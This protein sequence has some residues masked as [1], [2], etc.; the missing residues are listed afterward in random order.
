[1]T[2]RS[3]KFRRRPRLLTRCQ[4]SRHFT[5]LL[6]PPLGGRDAF[7][8][9]A[10][11]VLI[12]S[13]ILRVHGAAP[14]QRVHVTRGYCTGGRRR[15]RAIGDPGK[16]RN[17]TIRSS[18]VPPRADVSCRTTQMEESSPHD[19]LSDCL[20]YGPNVLVPPVRP[21]RS[22]R[23]IIG[24]VIRSWPAFSFTVHASRAGTVFLASPL[25]KP[26]DVFNNTFVASLRRR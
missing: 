21:F 23:W 26:T 9:S 18:D 3:A 6:P 1:M 13:V 20:I 10:G 17:I 7:V 11:A 25:I 16:P 2:A 12:A 15:N 4:L 8:A 22:I 5:L 19:H 14:P 24:S